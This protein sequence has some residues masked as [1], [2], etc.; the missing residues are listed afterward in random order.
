MFKNRLVGA[1]ALAAFASVSLGLATPANAAPAKDSVAASC[2]AGNVTAKETMKIR[3]TPKMSGIA[4][5]L[6]PKGAATCLRGGGP[7]G[8]YTACGSHQAGWA[9][10]DYRG[11]KG[12]VMDGCLDYGGPIDW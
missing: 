12:Y 11:M 8:M 10:I 4:L 3:T 5:G 1:A 9:Y 6:F 7:G 2:K